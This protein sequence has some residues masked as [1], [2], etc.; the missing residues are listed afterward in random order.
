MAIQSDLD[1]HLSGKLTTGGYSVSGTTATITGD[2]DHHQLE[3]LMTK[4]KVTKYDVKLV[5]GALK[6]LPQLTG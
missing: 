6:L 4:A 3:E 1:K 2:L 5:A